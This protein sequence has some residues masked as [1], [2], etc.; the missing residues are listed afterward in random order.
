M[1]FSFCVSCAGLRVLSGLLLSHRCTSYLIFK[2]DAYF[3]CPEK[4]I[5]ISCASI[6]TGLSAFSSNSLLM[7]PWEMYR[8]LI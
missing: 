5:A 4:M 1:A 8:S 7:S 3:E 6:I 2:D